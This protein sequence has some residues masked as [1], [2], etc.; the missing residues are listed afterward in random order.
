MGEELEILQNSGLVFKAC[1]LHFF[2][3]TKFL[4]K[5]RVNQ[6]MGEDCSEMFLGDTMTG[7]KYGKKSRHRTGY[8]EMN[9]SVRYTLLRFIT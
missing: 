9:T 6:I 7:H 8:S 3:T 2:L 4:R 1:F 5:C